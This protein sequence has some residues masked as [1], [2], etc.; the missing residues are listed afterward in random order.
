MSNEVIPKFGRLYVRVNPNANAGPDTLRLAVTD[1]IGS[2]PG[3]ANYSFQGDTPIDVVTTAGAVQNVATSI[4]F[5]QL[6]SRTA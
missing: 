2:D 1:S 4:N 3:A 5:M 6:D